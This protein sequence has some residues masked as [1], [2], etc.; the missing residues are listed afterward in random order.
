MLTN[1]A[2]RLEVSK[3]HNMVRFDNFYVMHGFPL[4]CHCNFVPCA[5]D[6]QLHLEIRINV[7]GTDTDRSASFMTS[8]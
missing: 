4:V 5:L 7:V 2:T 3:G 8:Y 6:I 1:R